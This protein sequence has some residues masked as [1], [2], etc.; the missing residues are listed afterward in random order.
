M[1]AT[2]LSGIL[3]ATPVVQASPVPLTVPLEAT[4]PSAPAADQWRHGGG[5]NRRSLFISP[6]GE[7]I[8]GQASR[9]AGLQTWFA[10]ADRDHN[11][12]LSAQEMRE[13]AARFFASLDSAHDQE[14][15]PE[16]INRYENEFAPEIR[17]GFA[18]EIGGR[19]GRG[20]GAGEGGHR[21]RGGH[22]GRGGGR[23]GGGGESGDTEHLSRPASAAQ[24]GLQGAGR[25]GLLNI[26]EP[27]ISADSDLNRGVSL[28][29]FQTAA[30]SRFALLDTNRD[31][32][33]SLNEL[34]AQMPA[35]PAMR[36]S[37]RFQRQP[38]AGGN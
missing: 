12:S 25:F 11:G 2:I 1:I 8:R 15:D 37:G 7:P 23:R 27:V 32:K 14:I 21:G 34:Q 20:E 19:P 36:M 29:E 9:E 18:P 22:G 17:T 13:D 35:M 4:Q 6:M 3:T 30:S 31:G 33:L 16:D 10:Q 5:G 24:E 38:D 26:P 28:P